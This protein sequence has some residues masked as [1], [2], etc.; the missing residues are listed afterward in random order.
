LRIKS[1]SKSNLSK[2]S[3][4]KEVPY[5]DCLIQCEGNNQL[6]TSKELHQDMHK[7]PQKDFESG[8]GA[9]VQKG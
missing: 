1:R 2:Y 3:Q 5:S 9:E 4:L 6:P 7:T 8:R